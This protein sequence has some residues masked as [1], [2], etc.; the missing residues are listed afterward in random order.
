MCRVQVTSTSTLSMST[1]CGV[2]WGGQPPRVRSTTAVTATCFSQCLMPTG[3][4]TVV[5][6]FCDTAT[7]STTCR[8]VSSDV[9]VCNMGLILVFRSAV[10][11]VALIRYSVAS[12]CLSSVTYVLWLTSAGPDMLHVWMTLGSQR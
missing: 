11:T 8:S 12:V 2:R 7:P 3:M 4:W 6:S 10:L 9:L 5:G 1:T